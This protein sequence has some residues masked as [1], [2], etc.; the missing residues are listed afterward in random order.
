MDW[1]LYD[2]VLHHERVEGF[3][4]LLLQNCVYLLRN[5]C[6]LYDTLRDFVPFVQFKKRKKHP[7]RSVAFTT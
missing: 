4:P 3:Y 1:F 7:W 6:R 5:L 2:R